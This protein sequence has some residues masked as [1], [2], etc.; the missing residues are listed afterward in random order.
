MRLGLCQW[1]IGRTAGVAAWAARLR[2]EVHA[3]A[4]E[5][6]EMLVLPEYAP[7]EL[8]AGDVPDVAGELA[9]AIAAA[10]DAVSA[11]RDIAR[12]AGIWLIPG[13]MP[14]RTK[15]GVVNRAPLI[16]PNGAVAFQ[17]KHVL[18]RFEA[19]Q[20]GIS[21]GRPPA[22][23]ATDFGRIGIAICFDAEFPPLVRAQVEAGAALILIPTCTDTQHGFNRV[24]VAAASRAMENQCFTALA[25]TV[26]DAPWSAALDT[27]RGHAA[28]FGPIDR[29]FPEDGI[30]A[31]GAPDQGQWLY[32]DI[33]PASLAAVRRDGAVRNHLS[34]PTTPPACDIV[35]MR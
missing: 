31:A 15:D 28:V 18:T 35:V 22:V 11:A 24:R 7:L 25:P 4:A 20:W 3:A 30:L 2:R 23:F 33:D 21:P 16:A 6:A 1:R 27:N 34:W 5:G 13:T 14:F 8:A 32:C 26:G 9:R 17:D 19:E 29:G 12:G 10:D